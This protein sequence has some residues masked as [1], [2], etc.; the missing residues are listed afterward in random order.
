[1]PLIALHWILPADLRGSLWNLS[2]VNQGSLLANGLYN[3]RHGSDGPLDVP[4]TDALGRYP[5]LRPAAEAALVILVIGVIGWFDYVT[6]PEIAFSIFYLLPIAL[7]A[8]R[9]GSFPACLARRNP[10]HFR[11]RLALK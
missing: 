10:L 11:W 4:M 6:G 5:H 2:P 9:L 7:A 8:W 3:G 1:M